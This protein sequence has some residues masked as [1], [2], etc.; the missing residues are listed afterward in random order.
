M[1]GLFRKSCAFCGGAA[2]KGFRVPDL[3]KGFVCEACYRHWESA[4]RRC[5]ACQTSVNGMQEVGAF[6][7]QRTLGH[8]DCGGLRLFA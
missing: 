6:V 8:A 7:E 5:N 3:T 1:F 4:G 2:S